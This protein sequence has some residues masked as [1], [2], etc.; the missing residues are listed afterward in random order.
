VSAP[1][2]TWTIPPERLDS[3][4]GLPGNGS[5]I[6]NGH[7]IFD[8]TKD[9]V[10]YVGFVRFDAPERIP[11][12][13][14]DCGP[15]IRDHVASYSAPDPYF[16]VASPRDRRTTPDRKSISGEHDS[17]GTGVVLRW[18]WNLKRVE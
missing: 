17:G 3:T 8:L 10:Q 4:I 12:A 1:T 14:A 15:G 13:L 18:Q 9:P 6:G 7:L 5:P 2:R 11:V 16:L